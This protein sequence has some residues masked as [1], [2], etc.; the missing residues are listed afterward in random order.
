M[1]KKRENETGLENSRPDH[2]GVFLEIRRFP[3]LGIL[4]KLLCISHKL[5]VLLLRPLRL[6]SVEALHSCHFHMLALVPPSPVQVCFYLDFPSR[7]LSTSWQRC[8]QGFDQGLESLCDSPNPSRYR[9][10]PSSRGSSPD[11]MAA[12]RR[13]NEL[14]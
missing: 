2:L 8:I 9:L 14:N 10:H 7:S 1:K 5:P 4:Q 11:T 6:Q 3:D 13:R 12:S